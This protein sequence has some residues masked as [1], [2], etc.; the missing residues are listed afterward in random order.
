MFWVTHSWWGRQSPM[1]FAG[2]SGLPPT[3]RASRSWPSRIAAWHPG[4]S[5]RPPHRSRT[6]A[7][8]RVLAGASDFRLALTGRSF[9]RFIGTLLRCCQARSFSR[10]RVISVADR[11]PDCGGECDHRCG[12]NAGVEKAVAV[13]GLDHTVNRMRV[14]M[15]SRERDFSNTPPPSREPAASV[16][17]SMVRIRSASGPRTQMP[18]CE[19]LKITMSPA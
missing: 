4:N 10:S 7:R 18:M 13:A 14:L 9:V 6:A 19:N 8:H 15:L 5:H 12:E 1:T 16:F 3:P 11:C 2:S 17:P